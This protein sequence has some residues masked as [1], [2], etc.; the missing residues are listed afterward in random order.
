MFSFN[1]CE[2]P[3][4]IQIAS[5]RFSR[6]HFPTFKHKK[7]IHGQTVEFPMA[8]DNTSFVGL[9]TFLRLRE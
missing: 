8:N 4:G 2:I 6:K 3:V 1:F 7:Q 9:I 5:S